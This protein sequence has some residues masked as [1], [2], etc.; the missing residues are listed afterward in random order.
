MD[1]TITAQYNKLPDVI[2]NV[3]DENGNKPTK[4]D[5]YVTIK[6]D[7]GEKGKLDSRDSGEYFVNPNK[8][9]TIPLHD[10]IGNT[11]YKFN[12]WDPSNKGRFSKDTTIKAVYMKKKNIT[13]L[14]GDTEML[15]SYTL[16][17]AASAAIVIG[18][19]RKRNAK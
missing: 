19:R 2:A 17:L 11:G 15:L 14:T 9:V 1:T 18:Y 8:D 5:G 3:P 7:P 13:P 12:K 10:A 4:P 6:V 16:L